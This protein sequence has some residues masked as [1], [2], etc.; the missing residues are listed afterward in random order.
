MLFV[1]LREF[2]CGYLCCSWASG[3]SLAGACLWG[4][5]TA[6]SLVFLVVGL[7]LKCCCLAGLNILCSSEYCRVIGVPNAQLSLSA[8]TCA[9]LLVPPVALCERHTP[10]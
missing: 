10:G 5:Y 6:V 9:L 8:C 3:S 7:G 2:L 4:Q 1:H